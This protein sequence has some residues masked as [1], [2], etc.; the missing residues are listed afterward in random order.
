MG[1]ASL[2]FRQRTSR[3]T[4]NITEINTQATDIHTHH[5]RLKH[6]TARCVLIMLIYDYK[7]HGIDRLLARMSG[8]TP[9]YTHLHDSWKYCAL[10]FI[11]MLG[12]AT[13]VVHPQLICVL[14]HGGSADPNELSHGP[15]CACL[16]ACRGTPEPHRPGW[17]GHP[18]SSIAPW[19][20]EDV[21]GGRRASNCLH[22]RSSCSQ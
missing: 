17:H 2:R 9:R 12:C 19:Q 4:P 7:Q 8:G 10:G 16:Q 22:I 1:A 14:L 18:W 11:V 21:P 6:Y 20:P 3:G 5:Q 13:K 15:R